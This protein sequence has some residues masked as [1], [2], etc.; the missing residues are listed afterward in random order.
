MTVIHQPKN[1]DNF[2]TT[3]PQ[4]HFI[5]K[6]NISWIGY[7]Q[8]HRKQPITGKAFKKQEFKIKTTKKLAR[9]SC[10]LLHTRK[11]GVWRKQAAMQIATKQQKNSSCLDQGPL[12]FLI[13]LRFKTP[14]KRRLP[15]DDDSGADSWVLTRRPSS[16]SNTKKTFAL[17]LFQPPWLSST[18]HCASRFDSVSE[19]CWNAP[20]LNCN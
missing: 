18:V 16:K 2:V 6:E 19:S 15:V 11:K 20:R 4:C 12:T 17:I 10:I 5:T 7:I 8:K 9:S 1:N 3:G 13:K 14:K